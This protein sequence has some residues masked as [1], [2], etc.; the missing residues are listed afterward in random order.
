MLLLAVIDH[1]PFLSELADEV[2]A[3]SRKDQAEFI[4]IHDALCDVIYAS[5]RVAVKAV[6]GLGVAAT[7]PLRYLAQSTRF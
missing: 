5:R 6:P 4:V 1:V 2:P 7:Q 3:E